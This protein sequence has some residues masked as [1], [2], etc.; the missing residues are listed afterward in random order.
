MR[1]KLGMAATLAVTT[2]WVLLALGA[3]TAVAQPTLVSVQN[4][5][6]STVVVTFSENIDTVTGETASNYFLFEKDTPGNQPGISSA[7]VS[8]TEVTLALATPLTGGVVYTL[9]VQNVENTSNQPISGVPALDFTATGGSSATPIADIQGNEA[10]YDGQVVTVEGVVYIP[11]NYRGTTI[12]GYIQ[13]SSG[14]GINLFGSGMDVAELQAV[15]NRVSVTGTVSTYFTTVEITNPTDVTLLS[16]GNPLPTAAQ[17]STGAAANAQWEGTFIEVTGTISAQAVSGPGTNY[18]INDGSGPI[19]VRV[20][21][22]LSAPNFSNG[23]TITARGAGGAFSTTFQVLVGAASD[24]STAGPTELAVSD[25]SASDATTVVVNFNKA[26]DAASASDPGSFSVYP[27]GQ[28]GSP[29]SVTAVSPASASVTLTLGSSLSDGVS[30]TVEV[31]DVEDTGGGVIGSSNSASFT[32]TASSATSIATIQANPSSYD[33]QVVTVE[34]VVYIPSDYRGATISGYIQDSSGRGINLFGSGFDVPAAQTVGNRIRVTGTVSLYFSTVEISNPT[35]V[36][37]LSGDNPRPS[38][39]QLSTGAASSSDW[40][41]TFIE[42]TG[43]I[44]S[45]AVG[46]PGTNYTVNDGSGT[47]VVR[48]VDTLGAPSYSNGTTITARGAGG[49]FDPDYQVLVGLVS[50]ISTGGG[51]DTDPPTVTGASATSANSVS[52]NFNEPLDSTTAQSASNY[53]LYET[54]APANTIMVSGAT[55]VGSKVTLSLGSDMTDGTSYTVSVTGVED[56]AGNVIAGSNT[57]S[58]TY[59]ASNA[60]PIATIQANPSSYDGQVVTVEGVVYIPSDYRG[61]TI[62]GYIQ[63]SSGRGI[64]LFGSGFDVPAAQ[65][66]GNRIRVTGTVSLYFSTVEISNPTEVTVLSGD[67][68]R[69]SAVQL[70]TGAA[71]SSDWEGTFIEVT[72]TISSQ[73]VGGP[74]TNY[75]VNDGSGTIVVRVVDT[76]GAPSYSNGTTIT[77]RGAGGYFD[78][79]YQVLVGLVSDISTGGGADTDPPTV[80]TANASSATSVS[81]N[82]NEALDT[83]TAQTASNYQVFETATPANT[84]A[85]S[86]AALNGSR[87]TL[88]LASGLTEG[89]SYT[90]SVSNVEDVAGN[91][92]AGSNTAVFT[93]TASNAIP[94]AT[95]QA[96]PES[97]DGQVVTVQGVVYIPSDYRGATTSGYIQDSSGRGINV[98]GSGFNVAATQ[99][100]GNQVEVTGTVSLYFTTVE[101]TNPTTVK[102]LSG[103]NPRPPVAQLSTGAAANGQWEG[104]FIEVSGPITAQAV[105]GPGVNYTVNDGSGPIDIRVVDTLSAPTFSNGTTITARGAGGLFGST[106]QVNVGLASDIFEGKPDD[107]SPPRI[108]RA[109]LETASTVIIDFSEGLEPSSATA[110]S[111]YQVYRTNAPSQTAG[112]VSA[113]FASGSANRI[114]LTLDRNLGLEENWSVRVTGVADLNGNAIPAPGLTANLAP[115][116]VDAIKLEGPPFTFLPRDGERYPLTINLTS[117]LIAKNGEVI[118]RIFNMNGTLVKTLFDSRVTTL[119][120]VFND[121]RATFE[122]DGKDEFGE[123]VPAGAYV[124][125]LQ[126]RSTGSDGSKE[127]QMPVVVASRLDR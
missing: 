34:G 68:P 78:P 14:R 106:Y 37:V 11:T 110:S 20:V 40:E 101:I 103:G 86:G 56:L 33:G 107:T 52:V 19:D 65:T 81:V 94:I 21:D 123:F 76:L 22:T 44:S 77:A 67:N 7:S 90:V 115:L 3:T 39:V 113:E 119:E 93:Y 32:F 73:A 122:W 72:G 84:F 4:T 88:T 18:T 111:N 126:T 2:L 30:Y 92:I 35:E 28:P 87:V 57:A 31:A 96:D 114:R 9:R 117:D 82:F 98:F 50:D 105:A 51:A 25:A 100:V 75:T 38:A 121:N 124:A 63:D 109:S 60:T 102:V 23:T 36:T 10:A 89:T 95:I 108:D 24:V 46:G 61:A 118:L 13:D 83:A 58:F 79:D 42:V 64:N 12:S 127:K 55:L 26:I 54:S 71:S 45:Q 120:S 80:T 66:V 85:V 62:S 125:H 17:L 112:V 69:P 74:G 27:T 59:T 6:L 49:Y 91:V 43:T 97:Y 29:F 99:T 48:V 8:G 70:S 47:I 16:S 116:L 1:R 41:G 104:T 15:G 5:D 53:Q